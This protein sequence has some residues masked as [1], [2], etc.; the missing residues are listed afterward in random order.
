MPDLLFLAQARR[1]RALLAAKASGPTARGRSPLAS[2]AGALKIPA[3]DLG[4]AP[5]SA[6]SPSPVWTRKG[7]RL[8][9]RFSAPY[10]EDARI[11]GQSLPHHVRDR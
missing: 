4:N 1:K 7:K 11:V 2:C 6:Y 9:A 10:S 5:L 3:F 8:G